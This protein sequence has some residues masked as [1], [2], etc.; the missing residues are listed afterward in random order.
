MVGGNKK[1]RIKYLGDSKFL[2]ESKT[3][4]NKFYTCDLFLL[5]CSCDGN[6]RWK[7]LCQ[8]LK[9][10]IKAGFEVEPV[11]T[12]KSLSLMDVTSRFDER[13]VLVPVLRNKE[14]VVRGK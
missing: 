9:E 2:V 10:L 14:L 8:H 11:V 12:Q 6:N 4:K 1:L 3:E 7:K 5:S 13:G